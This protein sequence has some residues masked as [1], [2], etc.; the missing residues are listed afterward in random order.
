MYYTTTYAVRQYNKKANS[1]SRKNL[2]P[3]PKDYLISPIT[4]LCFTRYDRVPYNKD[5]GVDP[6]F[7][8]DTR[9]WEYILYTDSKTPVDFNDGAVK[10]NSDLY[11][12]NNKITM[13]AQRE[14][15]SVKQSAEITGGYV[16]GKAEYGEMWID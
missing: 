8:D 1:D 4:R 2:S 12:E 14:D 10:L 3:E 11:A 6:Q 15:G 7:G 9:A 13:F 5:S 16:S